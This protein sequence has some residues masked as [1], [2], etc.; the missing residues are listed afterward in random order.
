[1][2]FHMA[3]CNMTFSGYEEPNTS[4]YAHCTQFGEA[5]KFISYAIFECPTVLRRTLSSHPS[6]P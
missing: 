1:M 5:D 4:S 3:Y 6:C 2:S